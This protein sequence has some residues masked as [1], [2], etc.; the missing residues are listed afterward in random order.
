M[1]SVQNG[2]L[3]RKHGRLTTSPNPGEN[4]CEMWRKLQKNEAK[5]QMSF[6]EDPV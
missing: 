4:L 5:E 3:L 2:I 1:F 6:N